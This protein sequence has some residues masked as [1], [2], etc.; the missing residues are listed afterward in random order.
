[1]NVLMNLDGQTVGGYFQKKKGLE[2][3]MVGG[4]DLK[5]ASL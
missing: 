3:G 1:M 4:E 5:Y 2:G